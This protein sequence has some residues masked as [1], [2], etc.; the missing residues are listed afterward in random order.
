M[1]AAIDY[2]IY[3]RCY[4]DSDWAVVLLDLEVTD[5]MVD[6]GYTV[7]IAAGTALVVDTYAVLPK[8]YPA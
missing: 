3:Y 7:L 6:T 5:R 2:Q 4:S 8:C 1:E